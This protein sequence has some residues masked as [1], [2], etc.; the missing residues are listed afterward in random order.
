[1][2]TRIWI[3]LLFVLV[4]I[5]FLLQQAGFIDFSSLL[6]TWWPI[7]FILIGISA[8]LERSYSSLLT[9]GFF[10]LIGALLILNQ[11]TDF[12][13]LTLILPLVLISIGLAIIFSRSNKKVHVDDDIQSFSLFSTAEMNSRSTNFQRGTVTTIFG[14]A[15]INLRDAIIADG[16][17]VEVTTIFGGVVL[18]LPEKVKVN[19]RGLPIFG[20]WEDKTKRNVDDVNIPLLK[21]HCVS[22]FG[23]L[24]VKN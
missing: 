8:L 10:M 20:G 22:I 17:E 9:G 3:G 19:I 11:W 1:M 15:E 14:S 5:G 24:E 18:Y 7:I 16:A 13:L 12:N 4:G 6:K 21:I 2:R 23:G